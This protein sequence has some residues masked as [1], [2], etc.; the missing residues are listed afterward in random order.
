MLC[1]LDFDETFEDRSFVSPSQGVKRRGSPLK[2]LPQKRR[3]V[4]FGPD[5]SPELFDRSLPVATPLKRGA[6]PRRRSA[7]AEQK[8]SEPKPLLK[9]RQST[10]KTAAAVLLEEPLEDRSGKS[11]KGLRVMEKLSKGVRESPVLESTT[12]L[13]VETFTATDMEPSQP[14][15]TPLRRQTKARRASTVE[16][17]VSPKTLN[18]GRRATIATAGV[19][20]EAPLEENPEKSPRNSKAEGKESAVLAEM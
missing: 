9:N 1:L 5:V 14:V 2:G 10:L 16:A 6:A 7:S 12:T 13:N 4:S 15:K 3:C 19:I 17:V 11:P 18:K 8:D 20:L